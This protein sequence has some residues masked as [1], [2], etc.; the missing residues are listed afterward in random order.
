MDD[1]LA[2][3]DSSQRGLWSRPNSTDL[4]RPLNVVRLTAVCGWMKAFAIVS[5]KVT[6]RRLA[7]P[8]CPVEHGLE[9]GDEVAGRGVDDSQH[10]CC[11][12]LLFQGLARLRYQPRIFHGNDRLRREILQ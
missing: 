2:A 4:P 7:K 1:S 9:D 8:Y 10:L 12:G 3:T 6:M 5:K 11:G